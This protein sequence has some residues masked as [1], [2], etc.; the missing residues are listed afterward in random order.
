[1]K[2]CLLVPGP[3]PGGDAAGEH[4]KRLAADHGVEV[5]LALCE[6]RPTAVTPRRPGKP[7]MVAVEDALAGD[8]DV[9]LATGWAPTVHLFAVPAARRAIFIERFEH[10]HLTADDPDRV[11]AA[12]A[13]DL[14]VD[15]IATAPWIAEAMSELRPDARCLVVPTGVDRSLYA[16]SE[17]GDGPLRVVAD[18]RGGEP[19]ARA[20]VAA[21]TAWLD[22]TWV[23]EGDDLVARA[24]A[25]GGADTTLLLDPVDGALGLP[26]EGFAAGAT[27]V[28]AAAGGATDLVRDG[29]NGFVVE[30]DD[31][32]GAARKLDGL[33][34]D[35]ELLRRLRAAAVET[36]R[37]WPSRE[38]A[39]AD[40]R[41][42][43]DDLLAG[44]PPEAARWPVR[45]MA[46]AMAQAAVLRG[47]LHAM[48]T[49]L[50][51]AHGDE[52]Y[53]AGQRLR[54]TLKGPRLA[55]VRKAVG[56]LVA[57]ARARRGR[58]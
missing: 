54:A 26:L 44:P 38:Q 35:R 19:V 8:Y 33:A 58:A 16:A 9:A 49:A 20:A 42:A 28:V 53:R 4:A 41:A 12:L 40:L 39:T 14:P 15:F 10:E 56:P 24:R 57:R 50:A 25:L 32:G 21:A 34:A 17:P 2:L 37:A 47:E 6:E 43:L 7:H 29:A 13:Y 36:G 31:P 1:V 48:R 45:L 23:G 52:A 51:S 22:V 27:T 18:A 11:P 5:T 55:P 30:P 3:P 46:D